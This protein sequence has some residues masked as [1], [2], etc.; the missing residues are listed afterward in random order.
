MS[1]DLVVAIDQPAPRSIADRGGAGRGVDDV[2]EQDGCEDT[3]RVLGSQ[4]RSELLVGPA[5]CLDE[6]TGRLPLLRH[7]RQQDDTARKRPCADEAQMVRVDPIGEHVLAA[8]STTGKI[9]SRYSSISPC[10]SRVLVRSALPVEDEL[11]IV[12]GLQGL[13]LGGGIPDR[14]VVFCQSGRW[15]V[16]ET[17]Y[18]GISFIRRA[19]ST[20]P[21]AVGQ[22][23]AQI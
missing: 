16:C 3:I 18:F 12:T 19:N 5:V 4:Q 6:R 22:K 8:P 23:A 9:S 1:S 15:S 2:G 21:P 14:M 11:A 10:A 17:T 13:H 7:I 20:S